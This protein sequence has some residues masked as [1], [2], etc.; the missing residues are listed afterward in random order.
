MNVEKKKK[1]LKI[2]KSISFLAPS[3]LGVLAFFIIPFLV[4]VYYSI[5][6][7]PIQTNFVGVKNYVQLAHNQAFLQ[8]LGNTFRFSVIAVPLAVILP[9]L[10][11]MLLDCRIP[12]KSIFRTIYISPLVVPVASVVL[13]WQVMFDKNGALNSII[14]GMGADPVN[15]MDSVYNQF[16]VLSLFLWK[17]LGYNMILFM[18]GL[19]D[20]P[21]EL[22]EVAKLENASSWQIFWKIK[23]RYL[24][25]T[26]FFVMIISLINSFK[27]FREVYLL[28]G[29]YPY[30]N[31]YYLQHFMNNQFE[32]LDYSKISTAAVIMSIF[33][34]I[35]IGLLFIVEDKFGKEVEE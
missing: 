10:L 34:V 20:I 14:K 29:G 18:A 31:I 2:T 25:S 32:K 4:I 17:N 35:I 28:T 27:I 26:V 21:M 5:I 9:L 22:I 8:A 13:V 11:A 1:L 19:G 24:S 12:G 30:G 16:I 33:M 15:W 7:N 23:I 6:D 3:G